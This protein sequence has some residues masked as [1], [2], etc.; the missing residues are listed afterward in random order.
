[1]EQNLRVEVQ[2]KINRSLAIKDLNQNI[3]QNI[4]YQ[5]LATITNATLYATSN[6]CKLARTNLSAILTSLKSQQLTNT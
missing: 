6:N 1:M 3:I 2:P 5:Q 4:T